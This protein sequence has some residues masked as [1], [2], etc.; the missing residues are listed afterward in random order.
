MLGVVT[1]IAVV[2]LVLLLIAAWALK[3]HWAF[4][5]RMDLVLHVI[6]GYPPL[7]DPLPDVPKRT[8]DQWSKQRK[9]QHAD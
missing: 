1:G 8:R 9:E 7:P 3:Q 5:R 4:K 6:N 2:L